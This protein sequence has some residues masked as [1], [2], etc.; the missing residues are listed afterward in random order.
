MWQ[1]PPR[2]YQS[3][4]PRPSQSSGRPQGWRPQ[5][6]WC[7][8]ICQ[9]RKLFPHAS[10][11]LGCQFLYGRGKHTQRAFI[12]H[13]AQHGHNMART[14]NHTYSPAHI[15]THTHTHTQR[16]SQT[17]TCTHM[18]HTCHTYTPMSHTHTH[19]RHT[20]THHTPHTHHTTLRTPKKVMQKKKPQLHE[21]SFSQRD[22]ETFD[23]LQYRVL[24]AFMGRITRLWDP[25]VAWEGVITIK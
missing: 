2:N 6:P 20:R 13:T 16:L 7:W 23:S 3:C 21:N 8:P 1:G 9:Y 5:G 17:Q 14:H 24:S 11:L 19:T 10:Q 25:L 12:S 15:S 18:S 4:C 22:P